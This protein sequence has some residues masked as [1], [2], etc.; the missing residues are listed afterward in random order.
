MLDLFALMGGSFVLA[1]TGAV[2]PGPLFAVVVSET[3]RT[4]FRAGPLMITGHGVLELALV[5]ALLTGLGPILSTP[6]FI[7]SVSFIGGVVLV[8]MGY[9]LIRKTVGFSLRNG[10]VKVTGYGNHPLLTGM[11]ASI[12]NPYWTLWWVTVGVGYLTVA[13]KYGISGIVAFFT[14]HIA[15]DYAWYAFV[16]FGVTRGRKVM[17][18]HVHTLVI[19]LCG[20]VLVSFGI[21]FLSRIA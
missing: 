12:S 3:L 9:D 15:A 11:L 16:S 17:G 19:R 10:E 14:G 8:V 21:W 18:G 20:V 13:L 5:I 7:K 1:L 6:L 4:G 2:V